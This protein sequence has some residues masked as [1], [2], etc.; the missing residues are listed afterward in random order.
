MFQ[1]LVIVSLLLILNINYFI[2]KMPNILS[3][4][5]V[6]SKEKR[7]HLLNQKIIC[8]CC[9]KKCL[10]CIPVT[11]L[12]EAYIRMYV[13]PEYSISAYSYPTGIFHIMIN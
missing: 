13:K 2:R 11:K 4:K 9:L 12:L 5:T 8:C 10:K 3:N 7:D 1:T 6:N